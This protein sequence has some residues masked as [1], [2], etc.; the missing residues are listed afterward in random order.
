VGKK[1]M[2]AFSEWEVMGTV[3]GEEATVGVVS[4]GQVREE[5]V[6]N[7]LDSIRGQVSAVGA[8]VYVLDKHVIHRRGRWQITLGTVALMAGVYFGTSVTIRWATL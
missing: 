5:L 7:S 4:E 3:S 6:N 1:K 8:E 2:H